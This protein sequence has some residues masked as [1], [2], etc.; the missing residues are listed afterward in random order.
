MLRRAVPTAG[1]VA[2]MGLAACGESSDRTP[3]SPDFRGPPPQSDCSFQNSSQLAV[4]VFATPTQQQ[5][6]DQITAMEA[7]AEGTAQ[8]NI[9]F[10]ILRTLALVVNLNTQ[11][12]TPAGSADFANAILACQSFADQLN[13]PIALAPSLDPAVDGAFEVRGGTGDPSE[14]VVSRG[15]GDNFA[16]P[17]SAIGLNGSVTWFTAF[18]E[19]VL[20]YGAPSTETKP[21]QLPASKAYDWNTAPLNP[22]LP[23]VKGVLVGLCAFSSRS[24]IQEEDNGF[25]GIVFYQDVTT[26]ENTAGANGRKFCTQ[27]TAPSPRMG[28]LGW[29]RDAIMPAP[30]QA[31]LVSPPGTGGLARGFST[32]YVIDAG[33]I[34]LS[35][36]G[37]LPKRPKINADFTIKVKATAESNGAPI[38]G[39]VLT[40][41]VIGNSGNFTTDPDPPTG[42]TGYDGVAD[43]TFSLDKAGGYRVQFTTTAIENATLIRNYE[44]AILLTDLF[45]L[46]R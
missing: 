29:L 33:D 45:H 38:A 5:V 40:A 22:L 13:L 17:Y 12:S 8:D 25:D 34:L 37:P 26:L 4:G 14:P 11:T 3:L 42:T 30:L 41:T 10:D 23:A 2:L 21:G 35:L 28:L 9:G 19:R 7:A 18:G 1:L 20:I 39:V 43:V 44:P 32:H 27:P 16:I 15:D 46:N 24:L 6:R 31:A 36:A